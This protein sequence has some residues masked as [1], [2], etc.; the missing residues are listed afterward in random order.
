MTIIIEQV[1]TDGMI[2]TDH[3][4]VHLRETRE[5]YLISG[6]GLQVISVF[7]VFHSFGF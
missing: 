5:L 7:F 4:S 2:P 1:Q 6:D 3:D